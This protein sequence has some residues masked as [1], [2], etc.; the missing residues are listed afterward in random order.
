MLIFD[1][2]GHLLELKLASI[3]SLSYEDFFSMF[4]LG[5]HTD[6]STMLDSQISPFLSSNAY[7]FW[8]INDD[9]FST[10]FYHRGYSGWA[11][12]LA[13][14]LF[15]MAGVSE[16]VKTMCEADSLE[17]QA[18]IWKEK[19][20]PVLLNPVVVALL[21]SPVF[22]WNALG[23]PMNQRSMLLQDGTVY[24]FINDTLTPLPATYSL[25]NGAYFYLLV[26][27]SCVCLLGSDGVFADL[28]WPLHPVFVSLVSYSGRVQYPEGKQRRGHGSLQIT[29]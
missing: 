6:F 3:Q 23:V 11:L 8:R 9:A 5:R 19:L 27:L 18:R 10:S 2:Q 26:I 28:A 1:S 24:D 21:K 25:K 14:F 7:Q 13:Q 22:C 4:G 15:R 12:R 17:E 16:D 29:H 20:Q